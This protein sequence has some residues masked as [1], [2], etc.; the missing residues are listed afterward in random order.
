MHA[1]TSTYRP[2]SQAV[3]LARKGFATPEWYQ[4]SKPSYLFEIQS[5]VNQFYY[6]GKNFTL[7][8]AV[9]PLWWLDR[10][11]VSTCKLETGH[12]A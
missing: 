11:N 12:K 10:I 2:P 6:I 3:K 1:A 7:G 5:F 9:S 8:T 4:N